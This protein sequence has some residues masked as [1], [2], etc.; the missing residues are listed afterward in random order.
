MVGGPAATLEVLALPS[1]AV[2]SNCRVGLVVALLAS[3]DV[4]GRFFLPP[5]LS[6]GRAFGD[7]KFLLLS[8]L[9]AAPQQK[10]YILCGGGGQLNQKKNWIND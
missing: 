8:T 4:A 1:L 2:G 10:S 6:T 9:G 5:S 7:P 3:G